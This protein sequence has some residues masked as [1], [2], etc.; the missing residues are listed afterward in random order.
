[1]RPKGQNAWV[2]VTVIGRDRPGIV[3]H[4]SRV[5]Y[6]HRCS[7]EE[8]AQTV[9]RG[10][11]AM[12]LIASLG[13][14]TPIRVLRDEFSGLSRNTGLEINLRELESEDLVP[15]QAGESEPFII[16]VRGEDRPGL[17]FGITEVL[18]ERGINITN[19]GARV[20]LLGQRSEYIQLFEV[21]VPKNL[22]YGLLKEKL[23]RRGKEMGLSV[24][25]Q[26]KDIFRAINQI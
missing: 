25:L 11:F 26:H 8:L 12:I 1:M 13:E 2:A 14:G 21:D 17:V 6:H 20:A 5:L 23:R 24:D 22:D 10:Q 9:L 16:T 19:L 4:V 15:Y 18:A 3:A 7:I